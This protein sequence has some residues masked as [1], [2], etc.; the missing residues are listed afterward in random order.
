[1]GEEVPS[2]KPPVESVV[3]HRFLDEAGDTTF[4]GKGKVIII[5]RPGVSLS[6]ALGMVKFNTELTGVRQA[7]VDLQKA[8]EK[9]DYLNRIYSV[10]KKIASGGFYF[11]ANED[12][13]EVRERF[14]KFIKGVDCSVEVAVGRKIPSLFA[15]KHDNR[16]SE[17]YADL[18][19]HLLKNKLKMGR[20]LVL[21]IAGRGA[22][23]K[24]TNLQLALQKAAER[25]TKKREAAEIACQVVFNVQNHRTEPL[26]NVADYLCWI[27]QRVFE[28]G[29][30]RYYE[31]LQEKFSLVVDLYDSANYAG[32]K[33][34]YRRDRLLTAG[35]KLSPPSP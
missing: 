13:P 8:V 33:N 5:G 16:E 2:S 32:S 23:T 25:F 30:I 29:E 26:L 34:Y 22:S 12:P 9:D 10:K 3:S 17:F 7:V 28:R 21:N 19:S 27:V 1:M 15:N 24:N 35:N 6:F 20:K 4:F 31:Y 14:F 11:H 18:L